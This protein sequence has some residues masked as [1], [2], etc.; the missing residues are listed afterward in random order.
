M[1]ILVVED[2]LKISE[3]ILKGLKEAQYLVEG[4]TS[5]QEALDTFFSGSIF[6]LIILDIMIPAPHGLEVLKRIRQEGVQTPV[7]ILSAKRSVEERVEGLTGGADDYLTKPFAFSELL[8]R[9]QVLLRRTPSANPST[10]LSS[11][12]VEVDL[13]KRSVKREGILIDLQPKEFA[14]LE[15]L[16]KNAERVVSKTLI[17]ENVYGYN[18]D[19]QTNIVDVLVFRLRNKLDKDFSEKILHTVRG[20]GYVLKKY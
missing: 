8:A 16:L 10:T 14:L 11:F 3:F 13:V 20:V 6:D 2:D 4:V 9:V 18:F 17:L 1:K 7:L 15:Y 5:G 12:G 19:T